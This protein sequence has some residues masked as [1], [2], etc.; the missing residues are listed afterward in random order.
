MTTLHLTVFK[1]SF[2]HI[3]DPKLPKRN[4]ATFHYPT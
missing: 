4:T 1:F 2:Q 3:L